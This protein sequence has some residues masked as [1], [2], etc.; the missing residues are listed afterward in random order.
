MNNTKAAHTPTPY[1]VNDNGDIIANDPECV[2]GAKCSM[3]Q[4]DVANIQSENE[5]DAAFIVQACNAHDD[6]LEAAKEALVRL[7]TLSCG[8]EN[9]TL[10]K[11]LEAA[12]TK[13]KKRYIKMPDSL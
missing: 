8:C 6:L 5:A 2:D 9:E 11:I 13:G 3:C 12:I 4:V 10:G 1:Y 7:N